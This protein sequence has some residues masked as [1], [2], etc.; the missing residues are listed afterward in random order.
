MFASVGR[1]LSARPIATVPTATMRLA[2]AIPKLSLFNCM[3]VLLAS[4]QGV[5]SRVTKSIESKT[6][7]GR[8]PISAGPLLKGSTAAPVSW[9]KPF[10][11]GATLQFLGKIRRLTSG[12]SSSEVM[13]P[14]CASKRVAIIFQTSLERGRDARV[15]RMPPLRTLHFRLYGTGAIRDANERDRHPAPAEG[16][17]AAR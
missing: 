4:K 13:L 5:G 11:S 6:Q 8:C 3:F 7:R 14:A 1:R 16:W 10:A 9:A 12:A 2:T 15:H 17:M